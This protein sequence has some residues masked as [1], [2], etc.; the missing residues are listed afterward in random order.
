MFA[1][2]KK[3]FPSLRDN[4]W[5]GR[6]LMQQITELECLAVRG[7]VTYFEAYLH[8]QPFTVQTDHRALGSLLKSTDLNHKLTRCYISSNST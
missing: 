7:V 4:F 6:D 8:G 2:M 1:G 3:N 5:K